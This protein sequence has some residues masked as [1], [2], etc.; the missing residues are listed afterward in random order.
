MKL[1]STRQ[2]LHPGLGKKT[3]RFHHFCSK[4]FQ[5]RSDR[6]TLALA[7]DPARVRA[8]HAW[9]RLPADFRPASRTFSQPARKDPI[10]CGLT[11]R[12]S[13]SGSTGI[14]VTLFGC[15]RGTRPTSA[16]LHLAVLPVR[17]LEEFSRLRGAECGAG[18]GPERLTGRSN[19]KERLKQTLLSP[20][21][22]GQRAFPG[23]VSL[24]L[25]SQI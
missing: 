14:G 21:Q 24:F 8:C 18:A 10:C 1:A 3:S 19:V 15:L 13:V 5:S 23:R 25:H 22:R 12:C 20:G 4:L 6:N 7:A 9:A 11:Y 17:H 16:D 2:T